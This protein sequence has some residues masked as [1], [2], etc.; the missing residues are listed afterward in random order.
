[1]KNIIKK[2]T[3]MMI[4]NIEYLIFNKQFTYRID[5]NENNSQKIYKYIYIM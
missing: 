1:M 4:I 3:Y 2:A 5:N